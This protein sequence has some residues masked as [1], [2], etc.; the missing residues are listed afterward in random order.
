MTP[1]KTMISSAQAS[2]NISGEQTPA[3]SLMKTPSQ[4]PAREAYLRWWD[5]AERE[6]AE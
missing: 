4:S 1:T 6:R 3:C 5:D 2:C